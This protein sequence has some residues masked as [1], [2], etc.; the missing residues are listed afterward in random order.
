[1]ANIINKIQENELKELLK[2]SNDEAEKVFDIL[3][4]YMNEP[5]LE[6]KPIISNSDNREINFKSNSKAFKNS[7]LGRLSKI[8]QLSE[9]LKKETEL[10]DHQM[11]ARLS[12]HI[13]LRLVHKQPLPTPQKHIPIPPKI[14]LDSLSE[15]AIYIVNDFEQAYPSKF[16]KL[17]D[18]LIDYWIFTLGKEEPKKYRENE[19]IQFIS[20]LTGLKEEAAF[21]AFRKYKNRKGV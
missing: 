8:Y 17:I 16:D 11:L 5:L 4:Y 3:K 7:V 19:F 13:S 12:E 14:L 1:M 9:E 10:L 18:N 20:I 6:L 15:S 21:N 2:L